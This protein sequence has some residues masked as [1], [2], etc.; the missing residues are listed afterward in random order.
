[1]ITYRDRLEPTTGKTGTEAEPILSF[2][3]SER[4]ELADINVDKLQRVE[5]K[6]TH[7]KG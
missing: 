1:M 3:F 6:A 2:A 4:Y 5:D 7:V